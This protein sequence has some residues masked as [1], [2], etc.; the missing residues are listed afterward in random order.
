MFFLVTL[1]TAYFELQ[2]IPLIGLGK[3]RVVTEC[4][5]ANRVGWNVAS[6]F[7]FEFWIVGWKAKEKRN[8]TAGRTELNGMK[9]ALLRG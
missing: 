1:L 7:G 2:G 8:E 6:R 5:V 4:N 3:A 9:D